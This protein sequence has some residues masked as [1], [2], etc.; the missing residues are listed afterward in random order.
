MHIYI[1]YIHYIY[2][3]YIYIYIYIYIGVYTYMHIKHLPLNHGLFSYSMLIKT[4]DI[5][6]GASVL[7]LFSSMRL[8]SKDMQSVKSA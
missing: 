2:I 4:I 5:E 8:D 3:I 1:L 7:G 6:E